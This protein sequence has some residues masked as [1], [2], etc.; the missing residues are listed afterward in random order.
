[1]CLKYMICTVM[2]EPDVVGY[3]TA[4]N[5]GRLLHKFA[6]E[7]FHYPIASCADFIRYIR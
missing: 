3:R 1:M 7:L 2:I 6:V 4:K 5:A